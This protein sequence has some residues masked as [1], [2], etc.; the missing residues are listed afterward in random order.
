MLSPLCSTTVVIA[1]PSCAIRKPA[2]VESGRLVLPNDVFM[3][4]WSTSA[5]SP[6]NVMPSVRAIVTEWGCSFRPSELLLRAADAA[7][8]IT[9]A[10]DGVAETGTAVGT[11]TA[12]ASSA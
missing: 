7:E 9:V 2:T 11:A 8:G 3:L 5:S 10:A 6:D 4:H 12:G 1:F